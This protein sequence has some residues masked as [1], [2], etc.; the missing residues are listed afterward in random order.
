MG[1]IMEEIPTLRCSPPLL[2][3]ICEI[4]SYL[5][6]AEHERNVFTKL[7]VSN[8]WISEQR[9]ESLGLTVWDNIV[10]PY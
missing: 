2:A 10:V 6:A 5:A 7:S 3:R 8:I 4:L 9:G 1:K